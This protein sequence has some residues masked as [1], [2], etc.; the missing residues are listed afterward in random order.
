MKKNCITFSEP[1]DNQGHVETKDKHERDALNIFIAVAPETLKCLP[2]LLPSD[3]RLELDVTRTVPD[4][5]E[6]VG[7]ID[8]EVEADVGEELLEHEFVHGAPPAGEDLVEAAEHTG[9][10]HI[11]GV[12]DCHPVN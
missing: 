6:S 4:E 1:C 9:I 7:E 2:V 10:A 5:H 11:P 12:R 8:D 3:T